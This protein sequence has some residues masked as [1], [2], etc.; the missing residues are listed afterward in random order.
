MS[1]IPFRPVGSVVVVIP[2]QTAQTETASGIVLADVYHD[3]E[4][5][6]TIVAVGNQFCCEACEQTREVSY[7]I[8]DRVLFTRGAGCEVDGAPLGVPGERFLLLREAE[9]LAVLEP[10][11]M[12]EVV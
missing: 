8:G 12:C 1:V 7:Q 2:H 6:G 5:S 10:A 11:A 3:A 4:T 9:L